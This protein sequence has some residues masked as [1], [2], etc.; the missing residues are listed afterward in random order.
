VR[1]RASALLPQHSD[2]RI[3]VRDVFR[4]GSEHNTRKRVANFRVRLT[5]QIDEKAGTLLALFRT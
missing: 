2:I 1:N 5:L 3:V 4:R